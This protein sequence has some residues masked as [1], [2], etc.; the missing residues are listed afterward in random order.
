[1]VEGPGE[2]KTPSDNM[3]AQRRQM[4]LRQGHALS[5]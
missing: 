5:E 1:M 3:W 2:E 4:P